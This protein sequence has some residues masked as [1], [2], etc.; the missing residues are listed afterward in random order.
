M[1]KNIIVISQK[2]NES[3]SKMSGIVDRKVLCYFPK[4]QLNTCQ[5]AIDAY[6]L[7]K[8]KFE[9][10]NGWNTIYQSNNVWDV[11][12]YSV[13]AVKYLDNFKELL[14]YEFKELLG[15]EFNELLGDKFEKDE[16]I[17]L[18]SYTND[19]L[20]VLPKKEIKMSVI[21]KWAWLHLKQHFNE[22][23]LKELQKVILLNITIE[24]KF[25]PIKIKEYVNL[26]NV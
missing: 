19:F 14:G 2:G 3:K 11:T 20:I 15:N 22:D 10:L 21:L 26:Q 8:N 7:Y 17:L 25:T 5:A 13:S 23:S 12:D 4:N 9:I 24:E 18:Y 16:T 1:C 6:K